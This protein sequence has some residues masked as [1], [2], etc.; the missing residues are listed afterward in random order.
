V[1]TLRTQL[2]A[3]REMHSDV[4]RFDGTSKQWEEITFIHMSPPPRRGHTATFCSGL[5][6]VA[7]PEVSQDDGTEATSY[8]GTE[9]SPPNSRPSTADHVTPKYMVVVGGSVP[10]P[11]GF[12]HLD[13]GDI[14]ALDVNRRKWFQLPCTGYVEA[15]YRFEHTCTKLGTQLVV[16]GGCT[17]PVVD[18]QAVNTKQSGNDLV[19]GAMRWGH[20]IDE[21]AC[22][23]LETLVWSRLDVDGPPLAVRGHAACESPLKKG[24][25][26]IIGGRTPPSAKVA[27]SS[28][29]EFYDDEDDVDDGSLK[30]RSLWVLDP[31]PLW[32]TLGMAGQAPCDVYDHVCVGWCASG[33]SFTDLR[34]D[35]GEELEKHAVAIPGSKVRGDVSKKK[36]KKK[37][38]KQ[39]AKPRPT[40]L[41]GVLGN[42]LVLESACLLVYGGATNAS[43]S[44]GAPA[45]SLFDMAWGPPPEAIEGDEEETNLWRRPMTPEAPAPEFSPIKEELLMK[46][47]MDSPDLFRPSTSGSSHGSRAERKRAEADRRFFLDQLQVHGGQLPEG[48]A[49]MK[50][51]ME[52]RTPGLRTSRLRPG[53]KAHA[54]PPWERPAMEELVLPGARLSLG[55]RPG[56]RGSSRGSR[57]PSASSRP[58]TSFEGRPATGGAARPATGD[59]LG[60][61]A[62]RRPS[63]A[64]MKT[65][66]RRSLGRGSLLHVADRTLQDLP[67]RNTTPWTRPPTWTPGSATIWRARDIYK[68]NV[69]ATEEHAFAAAREATLGRPRAAY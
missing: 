35:R 30:I 69:G 58:R 54:Q 52:R 7:E 47:S 21:V 64:S 11:K 62:Q 65:V 45:L 59:Q 32:R 46:R 22:L 26:L 51:V 34:R 36:K 68:L 60:A 31:V 42:A 57:R 14:W 37:K 67:D 1:A 10:D 13:H 12:E 17:M 48:Y 27:E 5:Q 20:V 16:V 55:S 24:E 9:T 28:D 66:G 25:L 41:Q 29:M 4:W 3:Q 49:S 44:Y 8:D 56:S 38:K 63:T 23:D 40:G 39:E 50:H 2:H 43:A 61:A 18:G 53:F 15:A 33:L 19:F 6:L